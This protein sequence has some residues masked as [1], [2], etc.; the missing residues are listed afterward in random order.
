MSRRRLGIGWKLSC[1]WH[2]I[3]HR[4]TAAVL[5]RNSIEKSSR[6]FFYTTWSKSYKIYF[7]CSLE[8]IKKLQSANRHGFIYVPTVI[9]FTEVVNKLS[10]TSLGALE[11]LRKANISFVMPVRPSV[12]MEQLGSHRVVCREI[13]YL[14]NFRK[15]AR[16]KSSFITI[17]Q[18]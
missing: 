10:L 8:W 3:I 14:K 2:V 7:C 11:K 16:E 18:T 17:W 15:T 5:V 6:F 4:P 9:V 1:F 12:R 13:L